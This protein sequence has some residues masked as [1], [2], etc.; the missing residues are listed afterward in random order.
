MDGRGTAADAR[1]V[2]EQPDTQRLVPTVPAQVKWLAATAVA[3]T[4]ALYVAE[5][6]AGEGAGVMQS[7]EAGIAFLGFFGL[8]GA[9]SQAVARF[10]E[11]RVACLMIMV[12]V[13]VWAGWTAGASDGSAALVVVWVPFVGVS[14]AGVVLIVESVV[15][16][17]TA[18]RNAAP[19]ADR[20]GLLDRLGAVL[21]DIVVVTAALFVP[22][23]LLSGSGHEIAATVTT[24]I[25][26]FAGSWM[27]IGAT[28]GQ[29]LVRIRV[30]NIRGRR[31]SPLQ[32]IG[33]AALVV[34]ELLGA[35]TMWLL[36]LI[37][38]ELALAGS[39]DGRTLVDRLTRTSV[40]N[41]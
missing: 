22:L 24:G 26:Y 19:P 36:P 37:V 1:Q 6:A 41:R 7:L 33:R 23:T 8:P 34:L 14:L 25:A 32:A 35:A 12:E 4:V 15:V 40:T 16:R 21:L 31:P 20:A 27:T 28:P 18:I 17:W 39:G 13:A 11:T 38:V 30:H 10:Q 9:S 2:K 3:I 29:A 5:A